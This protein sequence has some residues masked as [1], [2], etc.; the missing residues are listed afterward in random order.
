[1]SESWPVPFGAEHLHR[2]DVD[3]VE[4]DA[5][6]PRA[7]VRVCGGDRRDP[8]AVTVRV[9]GGVGAERG[10]ARTGRHVVR[11]HAGV[12]HRDRRDAGCLRRSVRLVP[13]DLRERPLRVVRRV[14]RRRLGIAGAIAV[15]GLHAR[16][17]RVRRH[18]CVDV[19]RRHLD[20][21][22]AQCVDRR[23]LGAATAAIAAALS[24]AL[25][26]LTSRTNSVRVSTFAGASGDCEE[27]V[28]SGDG[29]GSSE[30][31][32]SVGVSAGE[33]AASEGLGSA[34]GASVGSGAGASVA[35][36]SGA[37]VS[38]GVAAGSPDASPV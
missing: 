9:D 11:L 38:V 2:H 19:S 35:V 10:P 27:E 29:T 28:G 12:E 6:D 4:A 15:D 26:P 23:D 24:S 16:I 18:R 13:P 31:G 32:E 36:G 3:H 25:R 1:M 22:D 17:E 7:V 20:E 30:D 21:V 37:G 34:V 14:V 33:G 5:R 8:G